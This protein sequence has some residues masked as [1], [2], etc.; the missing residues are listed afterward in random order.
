MSE[1][2]SPELIKERLD[3]IE[4]ANLAIDYHVFRGIN[5]P[6]CKCYVISLLQLF[7]HCPDFIGYI[8]KRQ[9]TNPNEQL[10]KD[11]YDSF[12]SG[13]TNSI[14]ITIFLNEW[15]GWEGSKGLPNGVQDVN[16]FFFIFY[17]FNIR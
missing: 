17:E 11:I 14:L 7:F 4:H 2:R 5:N 8:S 6:D 1:K 9:L 13:K 3:N 10:L 12:N 15:K 16:E